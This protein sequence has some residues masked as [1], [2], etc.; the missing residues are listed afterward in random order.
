MTNKVRR[1]CDDCGTPYWA[2][3]HASVSICPACVA[4]LQDDGID[5]YH[6]QPPDKGDYK[7][8]YNGIKPYERRGW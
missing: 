8:R 3:P 7:P 1:E 6:K 4:D 2:R 5:P